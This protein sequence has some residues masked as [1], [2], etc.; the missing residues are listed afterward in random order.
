M[1]NVSADFTPL[2]DINEKFTHGF[3]GTFHLTVGSKHPGHVAV[4]SGVR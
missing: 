4:S 2:E 1:A 3:N